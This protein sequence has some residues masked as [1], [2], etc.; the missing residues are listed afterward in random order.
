MAKSITS[1]F[2][3]VC[4][5]DLGDRNSFLCV[6][7]RETGEVLE[8]AQIRTTPAAV[9]HRFGGARRMRVAI[10]AGTHS[11]WIAELL[12][13]LGHE[14]VVANPRKVR[15]IG[16]SRSKDDRID[17]EH[18]ARL[19]RVDPK[20]LYGVRHRGMEARADLAVIKSRDALVKVRAGLINYVR[21]MVK[22]FGAR[23][24]SSSASAF[25]R[26]AQET[27]PDQLNPTLQPI[28]ETISSL[29]KRIHQYDRQVERIA[30]ERYPAAT[31]LQQIKGIGPLIA[32]AYVLTLEDPVRFRKSREVGPYLGLVP[33]RRSSGGSD[34]QLRITKEGDAFLRRLLVNGAH[35]ILGPFGEDCNLRRHGQ[36]IAQRGGKNAKKRAVVAVARKLAVLMHRLW[37]TGEIYDPLYNEHQSKTAA[38]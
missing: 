25:A 38:A 9:R 16:E 32:L 17:A 33:A 23:I 3:V 29:T 2:E 27:I 31:H 7:D 28:L 15:L 12:R 21:G 35:Y 1:D 14:V 6:I 18:L 36:K 26:A 4:G 20:L 10:E 13:E 22:P 5:V 37:I 30:R 34:P 19:A 8:R 11:P 24:K